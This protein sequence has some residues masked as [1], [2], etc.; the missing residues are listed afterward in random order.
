VLR[1]FAAAAAWVATEWLVPR[2][3]GDSFRYGLYPSRLLRQAADLGGVAGLT[4]LLLLANGGAGC[5]GPAH[6]SPAPVPACC[7]CG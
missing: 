4:L 6:G 7:R 1:A 5:H 3:L 2:L